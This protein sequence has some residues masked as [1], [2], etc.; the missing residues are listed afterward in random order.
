MICLLGTKLAI[1][2][3][4]FGKRGL[5]ETLHVLTRWKFQ[6]AA[7]ITVHASKSCGY[8]VL[9]QSVLWPLL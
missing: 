9:V 5:Q 8:T 7:L 3:M 6:T 4:F 1:M 2:T